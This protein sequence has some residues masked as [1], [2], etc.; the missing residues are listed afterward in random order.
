MKFAHQEGAIVGTTP[1]RADRLPYEARTDFKRVT[2][3]TALTPITIQIYRSDL[4]FQSK[5][6]VMHGAVDYYGEL[7]NLKDHIVDAFAKRL[8]SDVPENVFPQYQNDKTA[9]QEAIPLSPDRYRLRL[10]LKDDLNGHTGSEEMGIVAPNFSGENL[11]CSSLILA[12]RIHPFP[13]NVER[14]GPFAIGAT[15]VRPRVNNPF[16]RSEKLGI[17]VQ[18]YNLGT[19][20]KTHKRR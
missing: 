14:P 10:F 20:E 2:N 19:D 7:T 5:D 16:T 9:N 6:G 12:D 8:L 11:A 13:N 15:R 1:L 3:E 4:Q 17:Y 18:V